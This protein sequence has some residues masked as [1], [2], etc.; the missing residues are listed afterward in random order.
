MGYEHIDVGRI[1]GLAGELTNDAAACAR[2]IDDY[3]TAWQQRHA[4]VLAA[5]DRP[6]IDDA[7][8]ALLSL[9]TSSEMLGADTLS[10]A[11]RALYAEA[12]LI[13][14]IPA[15]GADRLGRIGDAVCLELRRASADLRVA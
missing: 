13:G 7:L 2:F 15:R 3:V 5:V 8:A 10:A 6:V 4:R 14:T 12:R 1:R 11:A 9:A